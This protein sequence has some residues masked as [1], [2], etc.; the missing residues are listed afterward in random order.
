[1]HRSNAVRCEADL[2]YVVV[3]VSSE[4]SVNVLFSSHL[5]DVPR[6]YEN[7]LADLLID[8]IRFCLVFAIYIAA[9]VGL[10]VAEPEHHRRVKVRHATTDFAA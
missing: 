1:M 4:N 7:H 2:V 5:I 3:S 6:R 8:S 9:L 10:R